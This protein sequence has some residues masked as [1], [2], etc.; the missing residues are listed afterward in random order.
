MKIHMRKDAG[1]IL[2]PVD[3]E[4]A[5]ELQK[6]KTGTV[7]SV[8]VK[9][10]RNYQFLK[11]FFA[12][13]N[14]AFDAWEPAVTEFK[15]EPIKKNFDRFRNDITVLAGYYEAT[16]NMRGDVRMVAKSIS[17]GSMDQSEFD[18]LYSAV[19]DVILQRI[20]TNYTRDD[21]DEVIDRVLRFT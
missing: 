14:L 3:D 11:K 1:G 8:E 18:K 10:V 12:L 4:A 13:L 6:I 17:F 5:A 2:V 21:L 9:R 16:V 15:G 20:L 7:V 19:I